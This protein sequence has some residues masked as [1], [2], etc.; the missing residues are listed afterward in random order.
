PFG[1]HN[2]GGMGYAVAF[3]PEGTA[4]ASGYCY[5]SVWDPAGGRKR[6][7]LRGANPGG[8]KHSLAFSPDGK[9]LATASNGRLY[10]WDAATG[11]RRRGLAGLDMYVETIAFSPDGKW[12]AVG[13]DD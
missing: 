2:A 13:G 12:L 11:K 6:F 10:L 1:G 7:D 8:H 5:W 3:S 4:L 9:T